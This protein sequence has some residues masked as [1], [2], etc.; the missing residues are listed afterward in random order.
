M[1]PGT[2][3][4]GS[5][6]L[7]G[8]DYLT[9]K[10]IARR[11]RIIQNCDASDLLLNLIVL[12]PECRWSIMRAAM[13]PF[14]TSDQKVSAGVNNQ[15]QVFSPSICHFFDPFIQDQSTRN[16]KC[17]ICHL[18][19]N[20]LEAHGEESVLISICIEQYHAPGDPAD[21]F[22]LLRGRAVP[23]NLDAFFHPKDPIFLLHIGQKY[24]I[25]VCMRST[26]K[27]PS[28]IRLSHVYLNTSDGQ[29]KELEVIS[30]QIADGGF[31]MVALL[32]LGSLHSKKLQRVPSS[33]LKREEDY[34]HLFL[35]IE[36]SVDS[37][38]LFPSIK[39]K[40]ALISKMVPRHV[41]SP[42]RDFRKKLEE[43]KA[44]LPEWM[45]RHL[46]GACFV[47]DTNPFDM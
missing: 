29:G 25:R 16:D 45:R 35:D 14:F 18:R 28:D 43:T 36:I 21:R 8:P 6:A 15:K 46:R 20:V 47:L 42:K 24:Q 41:V 39:L 37:Q 44:R 13:S 23:M 10:A 27:L 12:E 32:D 22:G 19:E 1:F 40:S 4:Y 34:V 30:F 3:F 9:T 33:H 31:E 2:R 38:S 26:E 17:D 11:I 7:P 5:P